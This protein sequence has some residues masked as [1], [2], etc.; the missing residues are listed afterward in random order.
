MVHLNRSA[1]P[2][3]FQ[4][5]YKQMAFSQSQTGDG[6]P[7]VHRGQ[8]SARPTPTSSRSN[9][10]RHQNHLT[11][12]DNRPPPPNFFIKTDVSR[13]RQITNPGPGVPAPGWGSHHG[14]ISPEAPIGRHSTQSGSRSPLTFGPCS[15]TSQ[16]ISGFPT[17]PKP[18]PR[19]RR[20]LTAPCTVE[21]APFPKRLQVP[22]TQGKPCWTPGPRRPASAAPPHN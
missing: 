17:Q 1:S 15:N 5:L 14:V 2:D 22:R 9:E 3:R 7:A 16:A 19:L 10:T 8:K 20:K 21:R 6:R 18:S 11:S 13:S 4:S 12:P